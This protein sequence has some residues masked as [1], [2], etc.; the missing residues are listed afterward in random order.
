[1]H[2]QSCKSSEGHNGRNRERN[3]GDVLLIHSDGFGTQSDAVGNEKPGNKTNK[4]K[5]KSGEILTCPG[6]ITCTF[7]S[8]GKSKPIYK[9]CESRL[10]NSPKGTDGGSLVCFL[11]VIDSKKKNLLAKAFVFFENRKHYKIL[12]EVLSTRT[13]ILY[14]NNT[15]NIIYHFIDLSIYSFEINDGSGDYLPYV[16][17]L[18][19]NF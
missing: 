14:H 6:D 5:Y 7:E 3:L 19:T 1:M 16:V 10:D 17:Y 8:D 13:S 12:L 18:F 2:K 9:K 15:I 11:Q 4:H